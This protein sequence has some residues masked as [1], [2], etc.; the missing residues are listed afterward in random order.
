MT[1][2]NSVVSEFIISLS[3]SK[4]NFFLRILKIFFQFLK[5]QI[6]YSLCSFEHPSF[7]CCRFVTHFC[8][9][10]HFSIFA[11][12]PYK[13]SFLFFARSYNAFIVRIRAYLLCLYTYHITLRHMPA[14]PDSSRFDVTTIPKSV[15]KIHFFYIKIS[16]DF[17]IFI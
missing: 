15:T 14:P 13:I 10:C 17:M 9:F 16:L 8:V 2:L 12:F 11:H 4:K 7:R 3:L 6:F 5:S 1:M